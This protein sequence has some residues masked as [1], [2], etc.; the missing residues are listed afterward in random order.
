MIDHSR[1]RLVRVVPVALRWADMDAQGHVNN[2]QYFRYM[3]QARIEWLDATGCRGDAGVYGPVVK[4]AGC[5]FQ[6]AL[7]YPAEI[8]EFLFTHPKVAQ[9]AVFGVPDPFYGEEVMA[10]VQLRAGQT[11]SEEELKAFCQGQIAHFKIPRTIRFVEEFP[12]TVTG[13]LQKFRMRE[14]AAEQLGAA[15]KTG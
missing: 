14:I 7:V 11:A 13:K 8:E 3:E 1:F 10:W 2:V 5:T 4:T 9:V 15:G 6:R 12:T